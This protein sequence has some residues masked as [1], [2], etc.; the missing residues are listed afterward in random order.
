VQS[1]QNA[2]QAPPFWSEHLSKWRDSG[3]SQ[4]NYCRQHALCQDSFSYHKSKI[5][6]GLVL[7]KG[8]L[9]GFVRVQVIPQLQILI[10]QITP[11]SG[12]GLFDRRRESRCH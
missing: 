12:V 5:S 10:R 1:I 6:I 7:T 9:A 11:P 4:A 3:L 8:E 2:N